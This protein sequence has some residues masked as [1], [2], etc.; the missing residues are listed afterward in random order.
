M[1]LRASQPATK[2]QDTGQTRRATRREKTLLL[3]L[4][5]QPRLLTL[6]VCPSL[7]PLFAFSVLPLPLPTGVFEPKHHFYLSQETYP[8]NLSSP[9]RGPSI[10]SASLPKPFPT[11][12]KEAHASDLNLTRLAKP[13]KGV[14][15]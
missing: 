5:A 1:D 11:A 10:P 13:S 6:S 8:A 12:P 7:A 3:A 2:S 4:E 14:S 15:L 9:H